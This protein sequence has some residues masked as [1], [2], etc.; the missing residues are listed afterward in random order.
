MRPNRILK[1]IF[2]RV[3]TNHLG[4]KNAQVAKNRKSKTNY[5]ICDPSV[6]RICG[7]WEKFLLPYS[8]SFQYAKFKLIHSQTKNC[9]SNLWSHFK[10]CTLFMWFPW[11]CNQESNWYHL[12]RLK[13][14]CIYFIFCFLPFNMFGS[15][16]NIFQTVDR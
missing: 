8:F 9:F 1:L 11:V 14:V 5:T 13:Y 3:Y 2:F 10:L 7:E 12:L 6:S 16:E 15:E 4:Y